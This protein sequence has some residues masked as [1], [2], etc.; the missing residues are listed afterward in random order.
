M[1]LHTKKRGC[2]T[3]EQRAMPILVDGVKHVQPAQEWIGSDF[4][5]AQDVTASVNFSRAETEQLLHS[6][7]RMA[8]DPSMDRGK[9]P[10]QHWWYATQH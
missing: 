2:P 6:P 8:P 10:V 9:N 5:G 3:A 4:R 7:S 1:S